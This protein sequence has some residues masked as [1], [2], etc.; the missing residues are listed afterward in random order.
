MNWRGGKGD[1]LREFVDAAQR[2]TLGCSAMEHVLRISV[3]AEHHAVQDTRAEGHYFAAMIRMVG[4]LR[5]TAT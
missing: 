4:K 1:V 3:R 2:W 5:A